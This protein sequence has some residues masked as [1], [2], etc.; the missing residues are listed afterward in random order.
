MIQKTKK[1]REINPLEKMNQN[2]F[3]I[4]F[5]HLPLK[6][7]ET[8]RLKTEYWG[9]YEKFLEIDVDPKT[10]WLAV[11]NIFSLKEA[12]IAQRT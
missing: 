4:L 1:W 6:P 7:E 2:E 12:Q 10:S 5:S 3:L 11:R 8:I 9:M